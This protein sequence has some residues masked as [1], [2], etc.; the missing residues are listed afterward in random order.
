MLA[1]IEWRDRKCNCDSLSSQGPLHWT[2]GL[3]L[4]FST[5]FTTIIRLSIT[6]T[7]S[8]LKAHARVR[9][10]PVGDVNRAVRLDGEGKWAVLASH[11][12]NCTSTLPLLPSPWNRFCIR[13]FDPW[14]WKRKT[15]TQEAESY[16]GTLIMRVSVCLCVCV[17]GCVGGWVWVCL[18]FLGGSPQ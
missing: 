7:P 6:T 13:K 18:C 11:V 3:L 1:T 2:P 10:H 16:A 4:V 9:E 12:S 17:G 8:Q 14:H 15:E 5:I